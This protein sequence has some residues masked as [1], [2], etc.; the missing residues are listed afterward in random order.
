[1]RR[2]SVSPLASLSR[3]PN[4]LQ[5]LEPPLTCIP[6]DSCLL[7]I[8]K[9]LESMKSH[10][11]RPTDRSSSPSPTPNQKSHSLVATLLH[12]GLKRER[13]QASGH[14]LPIVIPVSPPSVQTPLLM[15][16]ESTDPGWNCY[17]RAG[18]RL[19]HACICFYV[20]QY[21]V[22]LPGQRRSTKR[23]ERGKILESFLPYSL[24]PFLASDDRPAHVPS[25]S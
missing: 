9:S 25:A 15:H 3:S 19:V 10:T 21:D 13:F 4:T 22:P 23:L 12:L 20:L 2:K 24:C 7:P 1:M 8:F 11:S 5:P 18:L 16:A 14:I 17:A 6:N